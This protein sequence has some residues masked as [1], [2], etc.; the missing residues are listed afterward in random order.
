MMF[1][2]GPIFLLEMETAF[3][4]YLERLLGPYF[5]KVFM[6]PYRLLLAHRYRLNYGLHRFHL[7]ALHW[8]RIYFLSH[9]AR[10]RRPFVGYK[11]TPR[12]HW[13]SFPRCVGHF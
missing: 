7:R 10:E 2:N 8:A 9:R 4:F 5:I 1:K 13:L 11:G 3:Q 12:Y 6:L